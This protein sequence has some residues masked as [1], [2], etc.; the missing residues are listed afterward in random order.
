MYIM[1][2]QW[3]DTSSILKPDLGAETT[4]CYVIASPAFR[5]TDCTEASGEKSTATTL[6][7]TVSLQQTQLTIREIRLLDMVFLLPV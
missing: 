5:N 2:A 6:S 4:T 1:L 3:R 7:D